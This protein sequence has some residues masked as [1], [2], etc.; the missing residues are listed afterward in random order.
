M[1]FTGFRS[2]AQNLNREDFKL[3]HNLGVARSEHKD[4]QFSILPI[5]FPM[6]ALYSLEEIN[7][8]EGLGEMNFLTSHISVQKQGKVSRV[9][10]IS[11]A[12][13]VSVPKIALI[14][15][16]APCYFWHLCK[17]ICKK[18]LRSPSVSLSSLHLDYFTENQSCSY[19]VRLK[20]L[21]GAPST[22]ASTDTLTPAAKYERLP[23]G[24]A[25]SE[26]RLCHWLCP[27]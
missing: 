19:A 5:K 17:L 22:A 8:K 3:A 2:T 9:Y 21:S 12:Q 11:T 16:S 6:P 15:A 4:D 26:S 1:R 24:T 18:T 14:P 13:E 25:C 27:N 7:E 10:F 23:L 20:Q